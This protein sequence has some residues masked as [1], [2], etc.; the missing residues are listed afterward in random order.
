MREL[1]RQIA[2]ATRTPMEEV[3]RKIQEA[4][5]AYNKAN[6]APFMQTKG[7]KRPYLPEGIER[8]I[9]TKKKGRKKL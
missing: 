7:L 8:G 3:E 9:K 1:S 4:I 2:A 6:I 5:T